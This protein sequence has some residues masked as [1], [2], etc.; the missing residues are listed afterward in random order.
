MDLLSSQLKCLVQKGQ[1][2]EKN[3]IPIELIEF[4]RD[5]TFLLDQDFE[6]YGEELETNLYAMEPVSSLDQ[7]YAGHG[8][9][10]FING[11]QND[12]LQAVLQGLL[13]IRPFADFMIGQKFK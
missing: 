7:F 11:G 4:E 6:E 1:D 13:R 2:L 10:S 12:C 3:T 8:L 5:A 9:V